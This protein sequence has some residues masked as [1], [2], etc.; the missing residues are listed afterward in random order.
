MEKK[1]NEGQRF[2]KKAIDFKTYLKASIDASTP[3]TLPNSANKDASG[4]DRN[5]KNIVMESKIGDVKFD[6]TDDGKLNITD[7]G[8][9]T[10]ADI[11][12]WKQDNAE[13]LK[14]LGFKPSSKS[15]KTKA[16]DDVQKQAKSDIQKDK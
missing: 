5:P 4:F 2:T 1:Y 3:K 7:A 15:S 16:Q 9:L 12:K 6:I 13:K 14:E 11:S 10:G 8:K